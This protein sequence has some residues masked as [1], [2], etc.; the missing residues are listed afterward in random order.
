MEPC[1]YYED[2][3]VGDIRVSEPLEVTE[4][5]IVEFARRYDPQYFHA[6][7]DAAQHHHF[8]QVAA[9]GIHILALWRQLDHQ[10]AGNIHWICGIGWD[11]LRWARP[12]HAGHAVRARWELLSKR[13]SSKPGRGVVICHYALLGRDD[14]PYF[15]CQSSNLVECRPGGEQA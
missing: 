12:L 14:Q 4:R 7:P 6:D 8:G 10:I 9:S 11:E 2:L 15:H 3:K 13:L 5:E 1:L